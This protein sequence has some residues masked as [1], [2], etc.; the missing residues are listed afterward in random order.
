[1]DP[2]N[3]NEWWEEA[4]READEDIRLGRVKTF[5][6]IDELIADLHLKRKSND[7]T[8]E[9]DALRNDPKILADIRRGLQDCHLG[10]MF[11]HKLVFA[12]LKG[13]GG[14]FYSRWYY[15]SIINLKKFWWALKAPWQRYVSH[16]NCP[17]CSE[18]RRTDK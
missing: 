15:R 13:T 17:V 4:E 14:R 7:Q 5:N 18:S 16:R 10:R 8:E 6:S 9:I 2:N 11:S 3:N 1:M 12:S